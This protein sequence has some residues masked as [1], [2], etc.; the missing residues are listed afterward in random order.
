MAPLPGTHEDTT[1]TLHYNTHHIGGGEELAAGRTELSSEVFSFTTNAPYSFKNK[2]FQTLTR[3]S[4]AQNIM[5]CILDRRM[6]T[7][8]GKRHVGNSS[9]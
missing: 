3:A 4:F 5:E 9:S 6:S 7:S 2:S 1:G 8:M